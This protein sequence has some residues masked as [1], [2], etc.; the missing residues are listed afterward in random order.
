MTTSREW[1]V[2]RARDRKHLAAV[3]SCGP[4]SDQRAAVSRRLDHERAESKPRDDAVALREVK[5]VRLRAGRVL[6]HEQSALR[7]LARE[8]EMR[9]WINDVDAAAEHR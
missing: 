6:R 3:V 2:D 1:I 5:L 7:D 9:S 8:R 4:R